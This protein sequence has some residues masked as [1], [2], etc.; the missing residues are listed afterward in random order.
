MIDKNMEYFEYS[1]LADPTALTV[2]QGE[3]LRAAVL[4]DF[5]RWQNDKLAMRQRI[6]ESLLES[7]CTGTRLDL[8]RTSIQ[9]IDVQIRHHKEHL[10]KVLKIIA[11]KVNP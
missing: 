8:R 9:H 7:N 2:K 5:E 1:E 3:A 11:G 4:E 10:E 6:L